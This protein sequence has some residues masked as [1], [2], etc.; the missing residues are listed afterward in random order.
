MKL[1]SQCKNPLEGQLAFTEEGQEDYPWCKACTDY[2]DAIE[3]IMF[4]MDELD[5]P[6]EL[7]TTERDESSRSA[8]LNTDNLTPTELYNANREILKRLDYI[9]NT[10]RDLPTDKSDPISDPGGN[11]VGNPGGNPV[12]DP[13]SD[14]G[15]N[16]GGNPVTTGATA[17][18]SRR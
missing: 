6:D 3:K 10:L 16:P 8:I 11:P 12:S 18:C 14:P 2:V 9:E 7:D 4:L 13:I 17:P 5:E 1:C 15:G